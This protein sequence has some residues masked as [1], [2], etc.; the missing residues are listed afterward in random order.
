[1]RCRGRPRLRRA[2]PGLPSRKERKLATA[3][4]ADVAG[5]TAL[6]EREDPEV[7]QALFERAFERA[8]REIERHGGLLEK[9][10]GDAILAVFGVPVAHED[11]PER[12]I[13]SALAVQAEI[14]A[15]A[16]ELEGEGR[17]P[18]A[19]RIG[20]ETG[21]ILVDVDRVGG[22]RHRMLTGDAVNTAARLE[23]AAGPGQVVVGPGAH[24]ATAELFEYDALPP[25]DL[26]GKAA[27]V[28]A[29]RAVRARP[30]VR[31]VRT[32]LRFQAHLVGRD[33]ELRS[34]RGR[35]ADAR[36]SGRPQLV[37][38]V[39][40]A[41]IGKSRLAHEFLGRPR[42]RRRSGEHPSGPLRR[43]R[44]RPVLGPRG[45]DEGGVR[46]A[47]RR[48][49]RRSSSCARATPSTGSSAARTSCRTSS[50]SSGPAAS[51]A[52]AGRI[53][54]TRWR[55]ILERMATAAPLVLVVEDAHWADDGL[56]D[57]LEHVAAWAT[58]PILLL[59]ARAA[60]PSRAT[61][62]WAPAGAGDDGRRRSYV[63]IRSARRTRTSWCATS[64]P[65]TCPPRCPGSSSM[66]A[67]A[68]RSS[69]R[70]SCG[71]SSTAASSGT[72]RKGASELDA[73][74][75]T[76]E[77]PRTIQGLLAARLDALTAEE[78]ALLQDASVV[79]RTFWLGAL[80]ELRADDR[81]RIPAVL[82]VLE[83]M[84]LVTRHAE[85]RLSGEAEFAFHHVLVRD[86]AYESLPKA[87]RASKHV[88]TAHWA[89][90][91]AGERR[92][93]IAELL[94]TH[95]LQAL[96]WLDDL[97]EA[98]GQRPA[99]EREAFRWTRTAGERARRLWQ[100]REAVGW[101]RS[102]L[103]LGSRIGR[104]D[105]ELAPL[106]ESY[107]MASDGI[108][109]VPDVVGAWNEALLRYER[110]GQEA[111]VGRV[112]AS[113]ASALTWEEGAPETRRLAER[114]IA[115]L[116]PLGDGADLGF[117]LYVLGRHHLERGDLDRAEPLLRRAT[118]IAGRVGDRPAEARAAISLGWTLH[119]RRRGDETIRLF[120]E[121]LAIAR[122]AGDLALL[123][124]ALEAVL[125]AAVEVSGDY[126]RAEALN[127]EAIDVA[128]R[129]GNL[130]KLARAQLNLGYLL[131]E[132]G[133]LDEVEAPLLA[134]REAADTSGDS[135]DAAWTWAVAAIA[136]CVRGQVRTCPQAD[137]RV[138]GPPRARRH[139]VRP[140]RGG[141]DGHRRRLRRDGRGPRRRGGGDP[142]GGAPR[143]CATSASRSGSARSCC[144]SAWR[145]RSGPAGSPRLDS[146]ATGS[147]SSPRRTSRR[148][149]SSPGPTACS[150]P[151]PRG[152]GPT[153]RT[154]PRGSRRSAGAGPRP[155][156][157]R[158]RGR[159]TAPGERRGYARR[160]RVGDPSI[161]R[162]HALPGGTPAMTVEH[163]R[164]QVLELLAGN[165]AH[166]PL[167]E[168]VAAFPD[169]RHQRCARRT[170]R[171]PRGTCSSTSGSPSTTSSST[172]R[173]GRTSS[174]AGRR[175]TGRRP[176]RPRR[177]ADFAA[178]LEGIRADQ[179]ALRAIVADPATDLLAP[180][181]GTPG[182]TILREIR[183]V[184][185]HTAYHVGEFAILRQVMGTWPPDR[186][187]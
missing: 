36:T 32:P 132:I 91:Q 158:P 69:A 155:V 96:H 168:A 17:P 24:A 28:P 108:A 101:L 73:P 110:T 104:D 128:G 1:M 14:G 26:R 133:R 118:A 13:R 85:S 131:R 147:R 170:S 83:T 38:V 140:V 5:S 109:T 27:P 164:E 37:T 67:P 68:T 35:C 6:A 182:H 79:G 162:R 178:T 19:L 120:D 84:G 72:G 4:F 10:I 76:L 21:A 181:P 148:A 59:R 138:P 22:A 86:V 134:A 165:G 45:G 49:R 126:M 88:V 34:W 116:E 160:A 57:F 157:A 124:D 115:R 105:A 186:R 15:L 123:L 95:H 129:A 33:A 174:R 7:V 150:S 18:L 54:S 130:V 65:L 92:D 161:V 94:A 146:R 163:L 23:Q 2:G 122:S 107:A 41:G 30:A 53:S 42:A 139:H 16:R 39:G 55:R 56:L 77:V 173:T 99:I 187:G 100:Q 97:G 102:A 114:A 121:A 166:M 184:A 81:D 51:S 149:R 80:E 180:I 144:S 70:R 93:E 172:S 145:P 113:I 117:A 112:E 98:N 171:T 61:G 90:A 62:D 176:T 63:S 44:E 142:G 125:S 89:E 31:G 71:C 111:D 60:G 106:W 9:F 82:G 25:L 185:D 179:E 167:E 152:L 47:G 159:R 74:I 136:A 50:R 29:W 183:L 40:P 119:A 177:A 151:T 52:S 46:G 103:D 12:A 154:P 20:I 156:P 11:D 143:A 141:G 153:S 169:E 66:P 135:R 48:S 3:L 64:W 58:A 8:E 127:R 43:V 137:R 175:S 87:L 78:K 75:E